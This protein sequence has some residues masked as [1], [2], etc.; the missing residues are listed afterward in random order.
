MEEGKK[1]RR[2]KFV[3]ESGIQRVPQDSKCVGWI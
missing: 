3:H 2:V 1:L